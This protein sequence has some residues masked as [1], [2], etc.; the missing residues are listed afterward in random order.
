MAMRARDFLVGRFDRAVLALFAARRR[1]RNRSP[2]G[3]F[4][5]V[6]P[7]PFRSGWSAP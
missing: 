4:L 6:S 1:Y 3:F 2:L 5:L 7:F